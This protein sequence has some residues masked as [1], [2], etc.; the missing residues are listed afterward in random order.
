MRPIIQNL[1]PQDVF[2]SL[3]RVL[4]TS[5]FRSNGS[6]KTTEANTTLESAC[7][8]ICLN[9]SARNQFQDEKEREDS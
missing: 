6:L 8:P 3:R 9:I 1:S 7:S 5:A 2:Q 4:E